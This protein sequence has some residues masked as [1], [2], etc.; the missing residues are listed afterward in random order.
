MPNLPSGAK[1]MR[2]DA[3]RRATNLD[4]TSRLKTLYKKL[5]VLAQEKSKDTKEKARELVSLF[6][7]DPMVL[8][9]WCLNPNTQTMADIPESECEI[10]LAHF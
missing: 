8:T 10:L 7:V 4:T 6:A 1:H 3:K 2:S 5:A 9:V